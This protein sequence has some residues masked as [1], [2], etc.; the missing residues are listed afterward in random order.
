MATLQLPDFILGLPLQFLPTSEAPP[1]CGE[2]SHEN[3]ESNLPT[4]PPKDTSLN[5]REKNK[6]KKYKNKTQC[7]KQPASVSRVGGKQS[8]FGDQVGS[9][10]STSAGHVQNN[11]SVSESSAGN[12][13]SG[14]KLKKDKKPR[15]LCKMCTGDHL[16]NDCPAILVIW[17]VLGKL[18]C[19][20]WST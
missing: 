4:P 6:D 18:N 15:F 9:D 16:T 17:N 7:N 20:F 12:N 1:P 10:T 19:Q 2:E 13:V 14:D 5:K 11:S 8:T 3:R